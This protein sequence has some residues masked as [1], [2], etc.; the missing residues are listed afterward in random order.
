MKSSFE[1]PHVV[2]VLRRAM[3]ISFAIAAIG[4]GGGSDSTGPAHIA[5]V[6]LTTSSDTLAPS[7]TRPLIA[8][9]TDA[10]GQ[11]VTAPLTWSTS[12]P[13]VA[14][15]S[16]TGVVTAAALGTA[17]ITVANGAKTA[18]DIVYV[19]HPYGHVGGTYTIAGIVDNGVTVFMGTLIVVQSP[20]RFDSTLTGSL[21]SFIQGLLVVELPQVF[22]QAPT[23]GPLTAAFIR[24][25]GTVTFESQNAT[26]TWV[27]EG[28]LPDSTL[29]DN[30]AILSFPNSHLVYDGRWD[31]QV[32]DA[33]GRVTR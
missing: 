27:F 23:T 4:C 19:R 2:L 21:S 28:A 10:N 20:S 7:E 9:A 3:A 30:H 11:P 12:N 32:G 25:D 29:Q 24:Q 31:S 17:V 15:V 5:N 33:S 22:A 8:S 16:S 13:S 1:R 14:S 18:S 6:V 26:S